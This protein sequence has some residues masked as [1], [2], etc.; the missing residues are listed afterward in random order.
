MCLSMFHLGAQEP[1][2]HPNIKWNKLDNYSDE[3]NS[4]TLNTSKWNT[5]VRDWG[6]WSWEPE[7]AYIKDNALT[8][9][10]QQKE[11]TRMVS[12]VDKDFYF[13]SG[14]AQ[15]SETI[16]YG[17][18]E[19][20]IKASAKGQG[21]CPAFWIYSVGQPDPT[22][23]GGVKYCEID[24]IEIFQ[25][26]NQYKTLEMNLHTR[27]I[28]NG[29]LTWKRPGQGD[30]ELCHNSWESDWDP[31]DEY[32]TY[33]VL[34]R[35]DS[36]FWYVDGIQRGAKKNYYWHLPMHVTVSMGLRTPYEKYI[37]GVRT[38]MEYPESNPE[39]G[40]PT[41]MYCDYVRVWESLPQIM[42]DEQNYS[43]KE[44]ILNEPIELEYYF[45]AGSG[46]L[47]DDDGNGLQV[48]L[49]EK[50]A[51]GDVISQTTVNDASIIGK[52]AGNATIAIPTSGLTLSSNLPDGNYYSIEAVFTSTKNDGELVELETALDNIML[53]DSP[54]DVEI[55]RL[56]NLALYPNPATNQFTIIG[57]DA[58]EANLSIYD[59]QGIELH[60]QIIANSN[61]RTIS[62]AHLPKGLYFVSVRAPFDEKV[63]KLL[64]L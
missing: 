50:N 14:I 31:R 47:V 9:Q 41:E 33:G 2:S 17:Y 16:T 12:G 13:T 59:T 57:L 63:L 10:M 1:V 23:E 55:N 21:T 34:N 28:E 18:F 39:P 42:I 29:V 22:E 54:T 48:K 40:F 45:D 6:T 3:F 19:A 62:I 38:V 46:F 27:I 35:P 30:T 20:K 49:L 56:S 24:V 51:N 5:D 8:L 61:N 4:E 64:K 43:N 7:N 32:H 25:I 60:K 37:N 52:P 58:T 53:V 26:P 11:H 44:F 36:I 15:I